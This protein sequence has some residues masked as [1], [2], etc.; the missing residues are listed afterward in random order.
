VVHATVHIGSNRI[1]RRLA[2]YFVGW[3]FLLAL[4]IAVAVSVAVDR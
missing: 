1:R 4:W 3:L 2:S